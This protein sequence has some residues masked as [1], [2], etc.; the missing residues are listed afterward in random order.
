MIGMHGMSCRKR[1][2]GV[3]HGAFFSSQGWWLSVRTIVVFVGVE[4]LLAAP[5]DYLSSDSDHFRLKRAILAYSNALL[6]P[7]D[8]SA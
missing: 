4:F 3:L 6:T 5:L 7:S 1:G 2:R 8:C